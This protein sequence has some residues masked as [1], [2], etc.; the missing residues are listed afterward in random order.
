MQRSYIQES[1]KRY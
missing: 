1:L